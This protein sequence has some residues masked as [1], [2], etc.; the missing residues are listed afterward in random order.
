METKLY[1]TAKEFFKYLNNYE[2][3]IWI[4]GSMAYNVNGELVAEYNA[5]T[6]ALNIPVV[7]GSILL[8]DGWKVYK[9]TDCQEINVKKDNRQIM[10]G[11]CDNCKHPLWNDDVD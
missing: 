3:D 8:P 4:R 9:C 6:Q 10:V 1:Q 11:F 2:A 7:S 5:E